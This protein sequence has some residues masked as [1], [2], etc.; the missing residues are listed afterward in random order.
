MTLET[1]Q[2]LNTITNKPLIITLGDPCGIGPEI[3]AKS[4]L[5]LRD[6]NDFVF[7]VIGDRRA[8]DS[9]N[10]ET[11][12]IGEPIQAY[13]H[14]STAIPILNRPTQLKSVFAEPDAAHA[15]HIISWIMEAFELCLSGKASA[16]ITA[17]I[18]KSVLYSSGFSYPGHTEYLG[19]LA[20]V[21]GFDNHPIMLLITKKLKVALATIHIPI[22]SISKELTTENIIALGT[23]L[24]TS[25]K[26]DFKI[27][28][29]RIAV[30]ALNPHA[31]EDGSI[32]RE[33]IDIIS[34]SIEGLKSKGISAT[35]PH[36]ADTMFHNE[37]LETYDAAI[38]MYHDQA[39][40]P[41]KTIDFWGGVNV[42]LNLPIVRTSPD[43]GTGFNIAGKNIARPDSMIQAIKVAREI[44]QNRS[45]V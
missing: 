6:T 19:Y 5:A 27:T 16:M 30:A 25:L 40:I 44:S 35:G 37:A 4:W 33:E 38:C 29:P 21:N 17:P 15:P 1:Q 42:T 9:F 45:L 14:F 26:M 31:G 10:V 39:L 11:V 32:G 34:P 36:P 23:Q 24:Y 28:A 2:R 3:I 43:H 18:A 8:F 20:S 22:T 7:T 41:L 13:D 12:E